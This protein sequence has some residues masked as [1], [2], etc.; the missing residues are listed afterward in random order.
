MPALYGKRGIHATLQVY[1]PVYIR[2]LRQRVCSALFLTLRIGLRWAE[3][4]GLSVL[5][6]FA[7]IPALFAHIGPL[8][9]LLLRVLSSI[10]TDSQIERIARISSPV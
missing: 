9:G 5:F 2:A 8:V 4:L 3:S 7:D 1:H 10:V 6:R